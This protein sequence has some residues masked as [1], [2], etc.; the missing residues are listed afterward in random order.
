MQD[1][2]AFLDELSALCGKKTLSR[3]YNLATSKPYGFLYVNLMA[4]DRKDMFYYK[5]EKKLIPQGPEGDESA[6]ALLAG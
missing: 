3:I 5:F 1:L 4:R 6:Q 2:N